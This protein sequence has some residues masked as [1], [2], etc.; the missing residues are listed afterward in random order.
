MPEG[1]IISFELIKQLKALKAVNPAM[2]R[3]YMLELRERYRQI[4]RQG[5]NGPADGWQ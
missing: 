5:M 3:K 4:Q 1:I 2:E